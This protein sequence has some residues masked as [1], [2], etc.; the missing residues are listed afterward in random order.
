[1]SEIYIYIY[2]YIHTQIHIYKTKN[3]SNLDKKK[4]DLGS[5]WDHGTF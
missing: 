2:I 1:M 5:K 4:M 3:C